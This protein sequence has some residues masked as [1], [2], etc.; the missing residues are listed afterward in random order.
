MVQQFR[1]QG[2]EETFG[3]AVVESV[4]SFRCVL[5]AALTISSDW[6]A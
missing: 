1:L 6:A 3:H 4:E 2:G 5:A